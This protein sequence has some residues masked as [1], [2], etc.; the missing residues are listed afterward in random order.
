[1]KTYIKHP[2]TYSEWQDLRN[3]IAGM[4]DK[5]TVR[6]GGSEIGT[7][8]GKNPYQT[9]TEFFYIACEHVNMPR[10]PKLILMRGHVQEDVIAKHYFKYWD[11]ENP[12]HETFLNNW[13]GEKKIFRNIRSINSIIL[14]DRFPQLFANIDYQLFK[15]RHNPTGVLEC[16]S[17]TK[18]AMDVWEAGIAPSYVLQPHAYMMV[19]G[20]K[21]A[22]VFCVTDATYPEAFPFRPNE[23]IW[24]GINSDTL[25]FQRRV[26]EGKKI[27]YDKTLELYEKEQYLS[28]IAPEPLGEKSYTQFLKEQH[29]PEN[30][31]SEIDG[32]DERLATVLE[33]IQ[34]REDVKVLDKEKERLEQV[35]RE[36]FIG[37]IGYISFGELGKI[38]WKTKFNVPKSILKKYQS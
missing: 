1:M 32:T 26:L 13:Y 5:N 25:E 16:K 4:G 6:F 29:R 2:K 36:W 34:Q 38:S 28:D 30:A 37:D 9:N 20:Y 17:P 8:L 12:D 27:T 35:I 23:K 31:K 19:T 18:R 24:A 22:E 21:Y 3:H 15:S 10:P 11:P 7:I 14:N 33:Y